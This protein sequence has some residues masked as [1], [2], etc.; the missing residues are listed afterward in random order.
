MGWEAWTPCT[1]IPGRKG[2]RKKRAF[3]HANLV[4][5]YAWP[6]LLT[7]ITRDFTLTNIQQNVRMLMEHAHN[8]ATMCCFTHSHVRC[9]IWVKRRKFPIWAEGK[10]QVFKVLGSGNS[11]ESLHSGL[12]MTAPIAAS[13]FYEQRAKDEGFEV[14]GSGN[15]HILVLS[16]QTLHM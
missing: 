12:H 16:F 11:R 7:P 6:S 1:V 15:S 13:P 3:F 8:S 14:L 2:S 10:R 5:V 4:H 9:G